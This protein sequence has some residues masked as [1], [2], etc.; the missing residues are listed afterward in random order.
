MHFGLNKETA[1]IKIVAEQNLS[2]SEM[3]NATDVG[4]AIQESVHSIVQ[5]NL[6]K[7][8]LYRTERGIGRGQ[9][10]PPKTY[11]GND[12]LT[13]S[14]GITGRKRSHTLKMCRIQKESEIRRERVK[15][16]NPEKLFS[17]IR[18]GEKTG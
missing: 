14:A 16:L 17:F 10:A 5:G 8:V 9:M 4:L 12:K 1:S 11:C 6:E 15:G 18:V 7:V 3:N 2:L 13:G